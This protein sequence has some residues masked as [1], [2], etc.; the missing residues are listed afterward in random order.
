MFFTPIL[1]K[2]ISNESYLLYEGY[3]I[4][5]STISELAYFTE[6]GESFLKECETVNSVFFIGLFVVALGFLF[7]FAGL[8]KREA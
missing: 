4:C 7:L 1:S 3:K 6:S 5:H 2:I 8:I